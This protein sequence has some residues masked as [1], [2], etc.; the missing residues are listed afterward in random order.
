MKRIPPILLRIGTRIKSSFALKRGNH[1]KGKRKICK[2]KLLYLPCPE[3]SWIGRL[4]RYGAQKYYLLQS[5]QQLPAGFHFLAFS[6]AETKGRYSS[7]A[8]TAL[9]E[10]FL[11]QMRH[12]FVV[13]RIIGNQW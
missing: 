3:R 9:C 10:D 1:G 13:T 5:L 8:S 4:G 12:Y 11:F 6:G 7:V 2:L